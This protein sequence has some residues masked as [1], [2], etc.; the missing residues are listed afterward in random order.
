MTYTTIFEIGPI[1]DYIADSRKSRDLWGS[2]FLFSYLMGYVAKFIID[3]ENNNSGTIDYVNELDKYIIS[4]TLK[5][6]D[7][8]KNIIGMNDAKKIVAGTINDQ[9]ICKHEKLYMPN[10][11][12]KKFYDQLD[13]IYINCKDSLKKYHKNNFK[14][15]DDEPEI[16]NEQIKKFFR[17]HYI[18]IENN[19]NASNKNQLIDSVIREKIESLST[20]RM[21]IFKFDDFCDGAN[22]VSYKKQKCSLCG[23]RKAIITLVGSRRNDRNEH[24]C[25]ICSIKRGL[26]SSLEGIIRQYPGFKSTTR[27]ASKYVEIILKGAIGKKIEING[28]SVDEKIIEFLDNFCISDFRDFDYEPEALSYINRVLDNKSIFGDHLSME[29]LL[30]YF[31][32]QYLG[33]DEKE[34]KQFRDYLKEIFDNLINN[35]SN[36]LAKDDKTWIDNQFYAMVSTDGDNTGS[37][38]TRNGVKSQDLSRAI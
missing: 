31:P 14:L 8:F 15:H 7:V 12:I 22:S 9:I 2:S 1:H 38:F 32:Y 17:L 21:K 28:A 24:L 13:I 19:Q 20:S 34:P 26:I 3:I 30:M 37:L 25:A 33:T 18:T 11:V 10:E 29:K 5:E 16:A 35:K 27:I 36:T 4:P 23:D 6:D